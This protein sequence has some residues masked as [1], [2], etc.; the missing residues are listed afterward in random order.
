MGGQ[1]SEM[2]DVRQKLGVI[3][4]I[5]ATICQNVVLLRYKPHYL[6]DVQ[7]LIAVSHSYCQR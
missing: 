3:E 1:G 7:C 4:L 5:A 6:F 2:E